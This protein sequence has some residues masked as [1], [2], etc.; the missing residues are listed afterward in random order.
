[1]NRDAVRS[2]NRDVYLADEGINLMRPDYFTDDI[3]AFNSHEKIFCRRLTDDYDH[4]LVIEAGCGNFRLIDS[5]PDQC[6]YLGIDINP[7]H[8]TRAPDKKGVIIRCDARRFFTNYRIE[9]KIM[10]MFENRVACILPFNFL[11]TMDEPIRFLHNVCRWNKDIMLSLFNTTDQAT[12]ARIRY[13]K[14]C[15]IVVEQVTKTE[16]FVRL[17]CSNGFEAFAFSQTYIEGILANY[18]YSVACKEEHGVF[19]FMFF[20][21]TPDSF[22]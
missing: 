13:Y 12:E 16:E 2:I 1:M 9:N 5:K 7:R 20:R 15:R 14:K 8:G 17:N 6:C 3:V 22:A 10:D 19:A 4:R 18:G 11:G 21:R